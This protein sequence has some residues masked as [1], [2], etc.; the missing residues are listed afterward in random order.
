LRSRVRIV[1]SR[2]PAGHSVTAWS[3]VTLLVGRFAPERSAVAASLRHAFAAA[4]V[5][6]V[7]RIRRSWRGVPHGCAVASAL[8]VL[9]RF[10]AFGHHASSSSSSSPLRPGADSFVR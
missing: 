1:P 8:A 9:A 5:G 7:L 2:A 4:S 6:N 10:D 3:T